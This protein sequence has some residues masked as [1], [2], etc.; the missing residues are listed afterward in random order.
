MSG[1]E[2]VR[3]PYFEG[4]M[5]GTDTEVHRCPVCGAARRSDA[6]IR[7]HI[8]GSCRGP[9]RSIQQRAAASGLVIARR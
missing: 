8:S 9:D 4:L 2:P 5:R 3:G 6:A 7:E 1:R